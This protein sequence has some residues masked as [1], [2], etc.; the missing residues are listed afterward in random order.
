MSGF[1]SL[2]WSGWTASFWI[3]ELERLVRKVNRFSF[4]TCLGD[5]SNLVT[6]IFLF[7]D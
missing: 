6:L 3:A 1:R 2:N 5:A 4:I 7:D